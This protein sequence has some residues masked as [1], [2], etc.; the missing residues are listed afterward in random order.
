MMMHCPYVLYC[1]IWEVKCFPNELTG[2]IVNTPCV[3]NH[4]T[5]ECG[6]AL[7]LQYT[8]LPT[9][10]QVKLLDDDT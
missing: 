4:S 10:H 5:V 9:K 8:E 3:V 7:V 1:G 2:E 6:T